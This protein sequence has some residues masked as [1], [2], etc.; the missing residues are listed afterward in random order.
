MNIELVEIK[1]TAKSLKLMSQWHAKQAKKLE[2]AYQSQFSV[3]EKERAKSA[4]E[5]YATEMLTG[6]AENYIEKHL[7]RG[8]FDYLIKSRPSFNTLWCLYTHLGV[9][10]TFSRDDPYFNKYFARWWLEFNWARIV[11]SYK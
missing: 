6:I 9:Q 1:P 4:K 8:N 7:W 3:E 11:E 5:G 10:K 2:H